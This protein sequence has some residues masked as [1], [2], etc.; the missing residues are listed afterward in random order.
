[1]NIVLHKDKNQLEKVT[2]MYELLAFYLEGELF[3]V[4]LRKVLEVS[5]MV[6]IVP[7]PFSPTYVKGVI[8]VRGEILPVVDLKGPL[9]MKRTREENR[10]VLLETERGKVGVL[11]D[12]VVGVMRVEEQRFEPNPMVGRYSEF[13]EKVAYLKEGLLCLLEMDRI[14]NSL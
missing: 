10:I 9:R 13:V 14:I 2:H 6:P 1:M 5:R 11:V 4:P 12:E 7:V 8:N 3:G